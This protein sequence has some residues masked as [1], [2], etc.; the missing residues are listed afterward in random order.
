[1]TRARGRAALALAAACLAAAWGM[2]QEQPPALR[3]LSP[4]PRL[5]VFVS[6]DQLRFDYLTRF[7]TLFQ[8]GFRRVLDR[9]ALFVNARYRHANTET[10]PGHAVLV[11]GRNGSHSGIIANEWWDA[12][13]HAMVNV[14]D[15]PA[16]S[17]L[18][19]AV[20]A[21][22]P[23][24]FMGF[25]IGDVLKR[26]SPASRVVSLSFKDRA[27]VL[28]GG[29][30]ADAAFWFDNKAGRFVSST[31]YM[32][33][34]PPWL[35]AWQRRRPADAFRGRPWTRLL[36]DTAAYERLA[37]PDAQEGECCQADIVFPHALKGQPPQEDFYASLRR[38][39]YADELTLE[40]ALKALAAYSLGRRPATDML[41]VGFSSLDGVGH[42]YG[43][44]SQEAMDVVLRLDR[45]LQRL[46]DAARAATANQAL[47]VLV[48]DHGSM[49]LVEVL[50]KRGVEARRVRPALIEGAVQKALQ[51]RFPQATG[52][53]EH[54]DSPNF[55]LDLDA[56]E[57]QGLRRADVETAV[58]EAAL[59]T[60]IVDRVYT[61][62]S[63]LGAAPFGDP[64]FALFRASFFAP[65]SPHVILRLK[66][67]VLVDERT[68]GTGH[69][70]PND[71]DRH[72]PLAFLGN[73]IAAGRYDAPCGPEDVAPTLGAL[74][75]LDYPM[76]DARRLLTETAPH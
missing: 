57:R 21:A 55:Y 52:L 17:P 36:P 42:T 16:Q 47:L 9:G 60:G 40:L 53:V 5:V 32:D 4:R 70:S 29:R 49:P 1:M 45:L 41:F 54:F 31:Y 18:G 23:A 34:L 66:E 74:L 22:S 30:R 58:G 33:A 61:Q 3:P 76:Q 2:P 14:V 64:D 67:Y 11:S 6:V 68:T 44:D 50:K 73:G 56:I 37:G 43:P 19:G 75:G 59:S 26:T 51:E 20:R 28:M 39:G 65:R 7:E 62:A 46:A 35:V 25:T 10:G 63:F 38:T 48:A 24:N 71:Y 69:G 72:V 15:D 8:G 12:L 27:A 13:A